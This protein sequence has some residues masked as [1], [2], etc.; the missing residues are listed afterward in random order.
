MPHDIG[1]LIVAPI[2]EAL[3]RVED[4]ALHGLQAVVG[5]R[6]GSFENHIR[7]IIEKPVAIHPRQR[8][9]A[10]FAACICGFISRVGF[11]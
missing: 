5:V 7:G 3:H 10:G 11:R 9:A 4:A 8:V 2:I 6:N 1:Y